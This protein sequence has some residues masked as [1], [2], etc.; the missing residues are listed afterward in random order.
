MK[1]GDSLAVGHVI[2]LTFDVIVNPVRGRGVMARSAAD[3]HVAAAP[4]PADTHG[5]ASGQRH[6]DDH[7]GDDH[8]DDRSPQRHHDDQTLFR[9]VDTRQL[10]SATDGRLGGTRRD[11][12]RG[13]RADRR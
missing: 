12:G 13:R 3:D 7:G 10:V 11:V 5:R 4:V 6:G 2:V 9:R 8:D 1:V